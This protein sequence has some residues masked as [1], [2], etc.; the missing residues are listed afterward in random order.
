MRCAISNLLTFAVRVAVVV[1]GCVGQ[2]AEDIDTPAHPLFVHSA[3]LQ[4]P[5]VSRQKTLR[6]VADVGA[7][8]LHDGFAGGGS[9]DGLHAHALVAIVWAAQPPPHTLHICHTLTDV[10]SPKNITSLRAYRGRGVEWGSR[11]CRGQ[12]IE[13]V[14]NLELK[15]CTQLCVGGSR[16]YEA[17]YR[18][19]FV[20][21][22][23]LQIL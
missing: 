16:E 8:T 18:E 13:N 2:S 20:D 5:I 1:G 22:L 4:W 17:F 12:K 14:Q 3:A 11:H 23:V 19:F 9:G 7:Q 15:Y 6:H 10:T 21:F